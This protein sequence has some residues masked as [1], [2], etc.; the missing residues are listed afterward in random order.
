MR[1]M[2]VHVEKYGVWSELHLHDLSPRL[3]V[4]FGRNEAGKT[5]LL[6]FVRT[7]FYGFSEDRRARYV[8]GDNG[9]AASGRLRIA[10]QDAIYDVHRRTDDQCNAKGTLTVHD[11][12]YSAQ[13]SGVL[14][15]ALRNVDEATFNNVFAIGLWELQQLSTLNDTD[16]A[17]WLYRIASGLDRVSLVDVMQR[18]TSAREQLLSDDQAACRIGALLKQR[19]Q[20]E[21]AV[22]SASRLMDSWVELSRRDRK[23]QADISKVKQR[24]P[25]WQR[26]VD[27]LERAIAVRDAWLLRAECRAE[28]AGLDPTATRFE[29]GLEALDDINREIESR[30]QQVEGW[31]RT[32][33]DLRVRA[34]EIP[35]NRDLLRNMPKIETLGEQRGLLK[36]LEGQVQAAEAERATLEKQWREQAQQHGIE[37]DVEQARL[38]RDAQRAMKSLRKPARALREAREQEEKAREEAQRC[39]AAAAA[40]VEEL[41][42]RSHGISEGEL[43]SEIE[44]AGQRVTQLEQ[45]IGVDE[46]I[47]QLSRQKVDLQQ[48]NTE[49]LEQQGL[50]V[51]TL[52]ATGALFVMGGVMMLAA[53]WF[54]ASV[55]GSWGATLA[56]LGICGMALAGGLKIWLERSE[57]R[58][59][60]RTQ[61]QLELLLRQLEQVKQQ[62]EQ[63]D[64]LLPAGTGALAVRLQEAERTLAELEELLP[65]DAKRHTLERDAQRAVTRAD[66]ARQQR[67]SARQQW[68]Q[69]LAAAH[70]PRHLSPKA[71]K[72][73]ASGGRVLA[74]LR[75]RIQQQKQAHQTRQADYRTFCD[76]LQSIIDQVELP[77][78][79][80][81][82]LAMLDELIRAAQRHE[83]L[84]EQWRAL[85]KQARQLRRRGRRVA[86]EIRSL[87][88]DR[89][90][91]LHD[92]GVRSEQQFRQRALQ[93]ARIRQLEAQCK[94]LTEQ[95]QARAGDAERQLGE[96]IE[97]GDTESLEE[98]LRK[99]QRKITDRQ[100]HLEEWLAQRGAIGQQLGQLGEDRTAGR[101][102]LALTT[103]DVRLRRACQ[104]WYDLAQTSVLLQDVL[105]RYERD[106]QPETLVRASEYFRRLT[107]HRYQRVWTPLDK[108]MLF[109]EASGGTSQS[110]DSLSSGT[111]EQLFLSLRL[112]LV[113]HYAR[114]GVRLPVVLDDVL[115]NFDTERAQEA[116]RLLVEFTA[117]DHQ[118]LLF[119]CHEHILAMFQS[120]NV[121]TRQLTQ[122]EI[123]R[124]TPQHEP[125]AAPP[126]QLPRPE[127]IA[128]ESTA[129]PTEEAPLVEQDQQ[130]LEPVN[131]Q[132]P[133]EDIEYAFA[134][135][136]DDER[137]EHPV[138]P[139]VKPS[140]GEL[141]E[142][143]YQL[144]D[145]YGHGYDAQGYYPG[146]KEIGEEV[147][148][149]RVTLDDTPIGDDDDW[150]RVDQRV[151]RRSWM[152]DTV[153]ETH[154]A[155]AGLRVRDVDAA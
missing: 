27:L 145:D 149:E 147:R 47:D 123:Q 131:S 95:I 55:V 22:S 155:S 77:V 148:R 8:R 129:A 124:G 54:P 139:S 2:D 87:S 12:E 3:T 4:L 118:L 81:S 88:E 74:E 69:A 106:H 40:A 63:L 117:H 76:R 98:E 51:W 19:R 24:L 154:V 5:T 83:P 90:R 49:L 93:A 31:K 30:Q 100:K 52:A 41:R 128:D 36:S 101:A 109:V 153:L 94:S 125:S 39:R 127:P 73:L 61:E 59:L 82:G 78:R 60:Q 99:T 115:V 48:Q 28:L 71:I 38:P 9:C 104:R 84:V 121:D 116:A 107:G 37:G 102:R 138:K 35:I 64:R 44:A 108:D 150:I 110:V 42:V 120:L 144:L 25:Q 112:A 33:R 23:L 111:R 50:P 70:L 126:V 96:L 103:A 119:T 132:P 80:A 53:L 14:A 65:L 18:L 29:E 58:R 130:D 136:E 152:M 21:D 57:A 34:S 91:L 62:R 16:A 1:I 32:Y 79:K 133:V 13:G 137:L 122:P 17:K 92:A 6:D 66:R 46:Q 56:V 143:H 135:F 26:R 97:S 146:S 15:G 142:D 85:R 113:D 20:A 134:D 43:A 72:K 86:R 151:R 11:G 114:L 68:Q 89:Q 7:V 141:V 10:L 105:R 67:H 75:T 140:N 45:R